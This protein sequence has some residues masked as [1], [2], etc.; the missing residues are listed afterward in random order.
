MLIASSELSPLVEDLGV[1]IVASAVFGVVFERLRIPTIAALLGAGV[2]VGPIGFSLVHSQA[3]IE[4][5]A[6]LGLTLLLFVIGLEVNPAGLLASGRTMVLTGALQVP[7]TIGLAALAFALMRVLD[8]SILDGTFTPLYLGATCAF[9]STLLV[10]KLLQDKRKLDSVSGRY[11]VGLLIFQDVWAI[12]FLALQPSFR[13]PRIAPILLT[14][15]G[16]AIVVAIAVACA[17][18]LLPAAF[19]VVAKVPELV[20]TVALGWCF[21]LGL[22]G[23]HLGALAGWIGID[24]P[25]SVSMEMCALIAGGSLA[26]SP[27]THEVVG[28]V[29]NLRDFF[30]T[31]FFV[32]LGMSIPVPEGTGVLAVALVLAVVAIGLRYVV[33]LPLLYRTGLDRRHALETATKLAQVS[34][35]CLVIAYLGARFGHLEQGLV[36]SIIFAFVLT[37]LVTPALFKA[38]DTLYDRVRPALDVLGFQRPAAGV[39]PPTDDGPPRVVI[40]GFHRVAAALLHDLETDHPEILP[41]LQIVDFNVELHD[42]IRGV[43]ARVVYGDISSIA[44]LQQ[45]GVGEA[46]LVISSVPDEL[47]KKTS[48]AQLARLVRGLNE[49]AVIVTHATRLADIDEQLT[50]GADDVILASVQTA[51]AVTAAVRATLDGNLGAYVRER[52]TTHERLRG[53]RHV[54]D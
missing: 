48:N 7:L 26:A 51:D 50:A 16:I 41:S 17:R 2:L 54:F 43:G 1:C 34:E 27:Y 12:V 14:F 37:A 19:R 13:E 29:T 33:F 25:V 18:W 45:A 44:T 5:I 53:R 15:L 39:T 38:S 22:V 10:V 23:V 3:N 36:S 4:T 35:F 21:G 40:L 24:V 20:V 11:C 49:R 31:L 8:W 47:L 30:V 6:N 9:S 28:K 46:E 52:K 42:G 32:G